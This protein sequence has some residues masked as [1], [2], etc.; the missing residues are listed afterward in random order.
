[1]TPSCELGPCCKEHVASEAIVQYYVKTFYLPLLQI[2]PAQF[3]VCHISVKLKEH[4]SGPLAA[5]SVE[6]LLC[7]NEHDLLFKAHR[8]AIRMLFPNLL[9]EMR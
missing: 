2:F 9:C 6:R 3:K 7:S 1:M 4:S 5:Q 8:I